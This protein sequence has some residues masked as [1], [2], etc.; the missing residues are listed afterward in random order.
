MNTYP[1]GSRQFGHL[2]SALTKSHVC[3][4]CRGELIYQCRDKTEELICTKNVTHTGLL[5]RSDIVVL[6]DDHY[7]QVKEL[8][9]D[10]MIR[11]TIREAN[12]SKRKALFGE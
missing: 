12:A 3:T 2:V 5:K 6:E 8:S 11:A 9:K 7:E 4:E 10:P 1:R